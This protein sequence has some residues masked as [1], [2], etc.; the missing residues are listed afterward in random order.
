MSILRPEP[1]RDPVA[2]RLV[3]L[4]VPKVGGTTLMKV[5]ERAY[6][7]RTHYIQNALWTDQREALASLGPRLH[8]ALVFMGH[9]PYGI[10]EVIPAPCRYIIV[11]RHPGDR[12]VSLY[13]HIRRE[14]RHHLH[15]RVVGKGMSLVDFGCSAMTAAVDNYQTRVLAGGEHGFA[16]RPGDCPPDLLEVA[17]ANLTRPEH[18]VGVQERLD[19]FI[20]HLAESLAWKATPAYE[21]MRV[22]TERTAF[23]DLDADT[24]AALEQANPLDMALYETARA[25]SPAPATRP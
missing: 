1:S 9:T 6:P 23:E 25:I 12:I 11:L 22:S 4:H 14:P 24:R 13:H 16:S 19:D 8:R 10:H 21:S 2:D 5:L 15:D 18:L 7:G 17:R 3:F 20:R